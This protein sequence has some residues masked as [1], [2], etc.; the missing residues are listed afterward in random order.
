MFTHALDPFFCPS[1]KSKGLYPHP[2]P[3]LAP[4]RINGHITSTIIYPVCANSFIAFPLI[5]EQLHKFLLTPILFVSLVLRRLAIE[6][7]L[8]SC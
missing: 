2:I 5:H 8:Y 6:I 1:V 4:L 7:Q 3:S